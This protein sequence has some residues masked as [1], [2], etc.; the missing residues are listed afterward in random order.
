MSPL[1]SNKETVGGVIGRLKDVWGDLMQASQN[2]PQGDRV[3]LCLTKKDAFDLSSARV[4]V[5]DTN[6]NKG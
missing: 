4:F 5:D 2:I 1:G 6:T 3:A